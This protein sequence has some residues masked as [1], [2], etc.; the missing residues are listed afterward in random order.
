MIPIL[1]EHPTLNPNS[2]RFLQALE[3]LSFA[4]E[5]DRSA[6]TRLA[7]ATDNSIYQI[8][9]DAVVF[10]T[11][12]EDVVRIAQLMA[13]P[14]HRDVSVVAR[15]GGTGTNGQALSPGIVVDLSRH[16]T[17]IQEFD[18]RNGSVRVEPGVVLDDLNRHVKSANWFF[19]PTLSPSSRATLGGMISTNASG[20][21][22]RV[23]GRT[24]DHVLELDVVLVDGTRI[25]ARTVTLERARALSKRADREGQLYATLLDTLAEHRDSI[26]SRWPDMPRSLTGYDLKTAMDPIEQTVSLIPVLAGS[27]GTL[28]FIVGA[29]LRLLPIPKFKRT[30]ALAYG[31]FDHALAAAEVLVRSDPSAIETIDGRILELAKNDAIWHKVEHLLSFNVEVRAVNLIEFVGE[32]L[33]RLTTK[34]DALI[35]NLR[36]LRS[37]PAG[38]IGITVAATEPDAAALWELR[39]KGVGLLGALKGDRRP[40]AFV[41]DTA[42]PPN[43]LSAYVREFR[44]ILDDAG[45]VY[46]MFGHVDVGCLHVRPALNLRDPADEMQLRP[47]SDQV[48]ALVKRYG[49]VFWGEHGKGFRSEYVP[50]FFGPNL[51][52]ALCRIKQAFDPYGQLNPGKLAVVPGS[53]QQLV[54]I[55]GPKRAAQDRQIAPLAQHHFDVAIHCNGNGQCFTTDPDSIMCP[56]S[57]LRKDRVHSPKGRAALI[58]EWLRQLSLKGYDAGSQLRRR[59]SAEAN[60]GSGWIDEFDDVKQRRTSRQYDF[61]HEVYD[62]MDGC[63]NCKACATQCPIKVDVPRMKSEFLSLYHERYG[64]PLRDYFVAALESILAVLSEL[65]RFFNWWMR[66]RWVRHVMQRWI[67]IVDTPALAEI[68]LRRELQ[69]RR[70]TWLEPEVVSRFSQL[71]EGERARH[72][73]LL[74]DAFTTFYEPRVAL[75]TYDLLI[76]LGFVPLVVPFFPNGKALVIKG[77]LSAFRRLAARNARRLNELAELGIQMIGIEPAVT[78]TYREEYPEH[79]GFHAVRFRVLLIQEWLDSVRDRL[80]EFSGHSTADLDR[81]SPV[82]FGHCT[83]RTSTPDSEAAWRRVFDAVG[84][85]LESANVGCCGMC[86][87]FGHESAH[88]QESRAIFGMSWQPKLAALDHRRAP[89]ATGHSCRSQAKRIDAIALR[90]PIECLLERLGEQS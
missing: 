86:G 20:K 38:P 78:L 79:L 1:S 48:V 89:L 55:D 82:L 39:K 13:E 66:R 58:R 41:E 56:S 36:S 52:D 25:M 45:L 59:A 71:P 46:G 65:P 64:R 7:V 21:G 37:E 3:R 69:R 9:P 57:K 5:I 15:G 29:T 27:E 51:F 40:I 67:G 30:I 24:A 6:A 35:A 31:E 49:G 34:I 84:L 17:R 32:D 75:A 85:K 70:A 2:Q 28:G 44:K 12:A 14:T 80:R 43:Q 68:S 42:V 87:V 88:A 10:P 26:E 50:E 18:P 4:G 22:S 83:E 54:T 61:S 53:D 16:M 74:Q 23:Y 73:I 63:L 76:K 77:F 81:P 33:E 19:G 47:I 11:C 90:H 62:A 72:V 8:L 60:E